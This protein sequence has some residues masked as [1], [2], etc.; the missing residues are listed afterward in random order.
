MSTSTEQSVPVLLFV[1]E[2]LPTGTPLRFAAYEYHRAP[3][4]AAEVLADMAGM[5]LKPVVEES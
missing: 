2:G 1:P 5:Y 3:R 4:T